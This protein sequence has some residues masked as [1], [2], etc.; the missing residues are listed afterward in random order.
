MT[1]WV[2]RCPSIFA[3]QSRERRSSCSRGR[4]TGDDN[5]TRDPRRDATASARVRTSAQGWTAESMSPGGGTNLTP[6]GSEVRQIRV[7][8]SLLFN[9]SRRLEKAAA[10]RQAPGPWFRTTSRVDQRVLCGVSDA[11]RGKTEVNRPDRPADRQLSPGGTSR[12][13]EGF[14]AA[15]RYSDDG[16]RRPWAS[17]RLNLARG[18]R[19]VWASAR[20]CPARGEAPS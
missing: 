9:P 18:A 4:P 14:Y 7:T 2:V 13:P 5:H 17:R 15:W 1:I 16:A 19:P 8:L 20:P 11:R 3:T 10:V 6:L 12:R